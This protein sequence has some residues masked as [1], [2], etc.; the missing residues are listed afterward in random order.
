MRN[1]GFTLI[2]LLVVLLIVGII[3]SLAVI[4]VRSGSL[5]DMAEEELR[6]VGALLNLA[7]DQAV[8]EGREYALEL[9]RD[10]YRFLR[11]E[12]GQWTVIEDDELF[13]ARPLVEGLSWSLVVEG[14]PV[15]V[16]DADAQPRPQ[17]L[18]Y[19]SGERTPFQLALAAAAKRPR[20]RLEGALF[21]PAR[22]ET[23]D[24]P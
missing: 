20:I 19:S 5:E 24:R 13:R 14:T 11:Y 3:A 23:L 22:I 12:G 8:L 10:G 4:A 1:S 15:S 2:E 16:A 21:E 6:R 9:N 18:L 17:V 7:S